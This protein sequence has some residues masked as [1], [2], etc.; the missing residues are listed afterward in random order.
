MNLS[1]KI[2]FPPLETFLIPGIIFDPPG[3]KTFR[4]QLYPDYK[5]TRTELPQVPLS[6]FP[7]SLPGIQSSVPTHSQ[8]RQS[9]QHVLRTHPRLRSR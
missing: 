2:F 6:L 5:K 3:R 4:D 8:R 9:S 7:H 1:Q